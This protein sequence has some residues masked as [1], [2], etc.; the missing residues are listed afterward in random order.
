M[1]GNP[2]AMFECGINSVFSAML[3]RK[4]ENYSTARRALLRV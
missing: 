3:L 2:P 4:V 1:N